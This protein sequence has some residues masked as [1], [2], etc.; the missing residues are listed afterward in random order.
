LSLTRF[1]LIYPSCS[2]SVFG[3][4]RANYQLRLATRFGLRILEK[5]TP[6]CSEYHVFAG[7]H[8]VHVQYSQPSLAD[9]NRSLVAG[10]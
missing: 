8:A 2:G 7:S 3:N 1:T 5:V 10:H 6:N 9:D 4:E